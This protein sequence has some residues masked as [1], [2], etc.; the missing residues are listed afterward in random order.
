MKRNLRAAVT[1]GFSI[2]LTGFFLYLAFRGTDWEQLG[3]DLQHADYVWVLLMVPCILISH[4]FRALRWRILLHP[5]K[6]E[7]SLHNLFSALMVGYLV[8]NFIPRL[9]ELVRPYTLGRREQLSKSAA[10]GTVFVER[11]LDVWTLLFFLVLF[12]IF[13]RGPLIESFPWLTEV[14]IVGAVSTVGILFVFLLLML[15]RKLGLTILRFMIRPL[16]R[17]IAD[18]MEKI[19]LS[20]LDG[21]LFV[22]QPRRYFAITMLSLVIW[23]WYILMLYIPFFGFDLV[24]VYSLDLYS[25]GVLVVVTSFGVMLPTPGATGTYHYFAT[26][27]LMRLYGVGETLA[28]S[29]AT[30][31]HAVGYIAIT[32]VG[33]FYFYREHVSIKEAVRVQISPE[34][35]QL[36]KTS[37]QGET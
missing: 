2:L 8:N 5:I 32:I 23:A 20:F 36:S 11:I 34:G 4:G 16:P 31:T 19:F 26:Q 10:L 17:G 25:A 18:R 7:I 6:S 30:V 15:R 28:L 21:F 29:Y 37:E 13:Y 27:T 14:G 33:L 1:Y 24:G 12:L 9:G 35:G 3:I 22:K